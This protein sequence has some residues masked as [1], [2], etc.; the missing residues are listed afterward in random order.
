[1]YSFTP[2]SESTDTPSKTLFT[3]GRTKTVGTGNEDR[4]LDTK[5]LSQSLAVGPKP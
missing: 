1:M 4:N 3:G 2:D 5:R